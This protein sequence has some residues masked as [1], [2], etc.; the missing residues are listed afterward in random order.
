[1]CSG[2]VAHGSQFFQA[3][4]G[5]LQAEAALQHLGSRHFLI[6]FVLPCEKCNNPWPES[7]TVFIS[8]CLTVTPN[9][10]PSHTFLALMLKRK[11]VIL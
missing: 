11:E 1:M 8:K 9:A 2:S 10:C 4:L 5:V 3:S 6:G 7:V